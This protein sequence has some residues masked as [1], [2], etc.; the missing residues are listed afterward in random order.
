LTGLGSGLVKLFLSAFLN[1]CTIF[2]SW[3]PGLW[4]LVF[5]EASFFVRCLPKINISNINNIFKENCEGIRLFYNML[6]P[7]CYPKKLK[8]WTSGIIL[9][10]LRMLHRCLFSLFVLL[11]YIVS[12]KVKV[13]I[14]VKMLIILTLLYFDVTQYFYNAFIISLETS[15][16]CIVDITCVLIFFDKYYAVMLFIEICLLSY[17]WPLLLHE[18]RMYMN[19]I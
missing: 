19:I 13:I 18:I 5:W 11:H 15:V 2:L 14:Y 12:W 7:S 10:I 17:V 8:N 3:P 16:S 6:G 9:F 4:R 1:F